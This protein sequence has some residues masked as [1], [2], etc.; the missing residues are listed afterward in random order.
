MSDTDL[1]RR[2]K[3]FMGCEGDDVIS[4]LKLDTKVVVIRRAT[5]IHAGELQKDM[6]AEVERLRRQNADVTA[7]SM[8]RL[9]RL[10]DHNI[11][12][13]VYEQEYGVDEYT[14]EAVE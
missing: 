12:D 9:T 3:A 4:L 2:H 13:P 10:Q 1:E 8:E 14:G 7:R 11:S 5:L 6:L